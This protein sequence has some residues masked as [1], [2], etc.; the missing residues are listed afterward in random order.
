MVGGPHTGTLDRRDG[1]R[2]GPVVFHPT[3]RQPP[4]S[5][6]IPQPHRLQSTRAHAPSGFLTSIH[7]Q[8][9]RY[10]VNDNLPVLVRPSLGNLSVSLTLT[11]SLHP[12]STHS[13][14]H[15]HPLFLQNHPP[16]FHSEIQIQQHTVRSSHKQQ[17]LRHRIV[18]VVFIQPPH[19]HRFPQQSLRITL[20]YLAPPSGSGSHFAY[21]LASS[22]LYQ[23][24]LV[25]YPKR[26]PKRRPGS[27]PEK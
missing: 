7:S 12:T 23:I 27:S 5:I 6:T 8:R 9:C 25:V 20:Q 15:H 16:W 11:P 18:S 2:A 26:A 24:I 14:T 1:H 22:L 10:L 4:A 3:R 19:G 17:S 21:H 13:A